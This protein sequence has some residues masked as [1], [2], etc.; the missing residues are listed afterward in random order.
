MNKLARQETGGATHD[1]GVIPLDPYGAPAVAAQN[2]VRAALSFVR[3]NA[4]GAVKSAPDSSIFVNGLGE[5]VVR[6]AHFV[7][8]SGEMAMRVMVDRGAPDE[9]DPSQL[10]EVHELHLG[11]SYGKAVDETGTPV[12]DA[13]VHIQTFP[14]MKTA[15]VT[16]ASDRFD[17]PVMLTDV[18]L[19]DI[20]L[21]PTAL[22]VELRRSPDM[23]DAPT[24]DRVNVGFVDTAGQM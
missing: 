10:G 9:M 14:G 3:E 2:F 11:A 1:S 17:T 5:R 22:A 21:E 7:E 6:T 8:G 12:F 20:R 4:Q 15:D 13:E 18:P 24:E 23:L 16:I 19:A